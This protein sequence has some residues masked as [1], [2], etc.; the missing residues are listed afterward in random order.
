MSMHPAAKTGG[1]DLPGA[2]TYTANLNKLLKTTTSQP[3]LYSRLQYQFLAN[4]LSPQGYSQDT[5]SVNFIHAQQRSRQNTDAFV[6]VVVHT[7]SSGSHLQRD[8]FDLKNGLARFVNHS[9]PEANSNQIVFVRGSLS[10]AWIDALG[11][12]YKI[13]PEFFRRHLRYLPGRDYSDLP[14]LPSANSEMMTL[15]LSSLYTRTHPLAPGQIRKC[16]EKDEDVARKNQ[17]S[18]S[19][20]LACGETVIRRFSTLS[21]R[22]FSVEHEI[23]IFTRRRKNGGQIGK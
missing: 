4:Y 10:A 12:K 22:L 15:I 23:S 14:S 11:T 5:Q 13:D 6:H 9:Q 16:R 2:R 18:I 21:D 7:F 8:D 1:S 17:M 19:G 20:D 3:A